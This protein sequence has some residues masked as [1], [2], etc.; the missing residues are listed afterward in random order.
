MMLIAFILVVLTSA[1][2]VMLR[3]LNARPLTDYDNV[4]TLRALSEA[5]QALIGYAVAYP[6]RVN[7]AFGPGYLPC[8]DDPAD[9]TA[10]IARSAC[11]SATNSNTGRFP[12]ATLDTHALRD[13]SGARLWY[14][15]TDEVRYNPHLTPL[16]SDTPGSLTVDGAGDI[17]AVIIAPGA[18][19]AGQ[20]SRAANPNLP[21]AFLE[22]DNA[23]N[24]DNSFTRNP[25]GG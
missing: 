10:G 16:N 24:G 3:S 25:A 20:A 9:A 11:A 4:A 2:F 23:T 22:G 13:A 7:A 19:V 14:A 15:L 18:P 17:V 5:K 1:S 12:W 8:P 21:A 6:D